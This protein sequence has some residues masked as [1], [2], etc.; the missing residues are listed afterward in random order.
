MNQIRQK[1]P[2]TDLPGCIRRLSNVERLFLW[3]F[4]T[5]IAVAARIGGDVEEEKLERAIDAVC[6]RHPLT[7]CKIIF[8]EHHD[9]WF[10]GDSVPRATLRIVPRTS[11]SQWFD[12]VRLEYKVPFEPEIGP[13]IRF[14][15]VY[16]PEVSELMVFS[17]HCICDGTALANLI[18]DLLSC[19]A[20]PKK[21]FPVISPPAITDY[22]QKK[23]SFSISE[24]IGNFFINRYNNQWLKN[25]YY[26]SQE[27]FN[28]IHAAYWEKNRYSIALLK[29]EPEETCNLTARCREK[30]VTIGSAL[31]AAFLAAYCEV[32][33]PLPK[34]KRTISIPFDLRRHFKEGRVEGFCFLSGG[35]N[36]P[37]AYD[38]KK[39]FWKNTADLHKII[40]RRVGMLDNTGLD[41]EHFDP[42]LIDAFFNLAPYTKQIPD[43]FN[44]TENL[45][46]FARDKK[47]PAI[48]ISNKILS[49]LPGFITTNL[50]RLDYPEM[51]GDLRLDR[52]FLI[53][54]TGE[55]VPLV[56]GGVGVC[57][58]LT[59]SLNYLERNDSNDSSSTRD[60]IRIRNRAL[61]YLGFPEKANESAM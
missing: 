38:Q 44:Q 12:E 4:Q 23:N 31:A 58:K 13:L 49:K 52:M 5:N 34:N 48:T 11:D 50:G 20:F 21:K 32:I 45:S 6:R 33:G 57:S 18:Y 9:A 29:L 10:S 27:D 61:E 60:M 41:M 7:R 24:I 55:Y 53:P 39:S 14:V 36:F 35:F 22:L 17:E 37:F 28:G 56:L 43:A 19:Y 51:Y 42:T 3:S 16:S 25:P 26:I 54:S 15:L 46:A 47:S 59:F 1:S 8:D 2:P 40:Q 30:G